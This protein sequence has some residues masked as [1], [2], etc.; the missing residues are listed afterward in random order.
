M[1]GRLWDTSR[2]SQGSGRD[3]LSHAFADAGMCLTPDGS[4]LLSTDLHV[5]C[6]SQ[7]DLS[8]NFLCGVWFEFGQQKGTY[9]TKGIEAIAHTLRVTTSLK[10][11]R[12]LALVL[13]PLMYDRCLH[14]LLRKAHACIRCSCLQLNLGRNQVG[15]KGAEALAPGLATSRSLK[16]LNLSYN[17]IGPKLGT[18]M[19]EVLKANG[20]L[21]SLDLKENNI[22]SKGAKAMGEALAANSSLKDCQ[23]RCNNL[24]SEGWATIFNTLCQSSTNQIVTWDLSNEGIISETAGVTNSLAKYLSA[25]PSLTALDA[26][27]NTWSAAAV[28]QLNAV[29]A[30]RSSRISI[31]L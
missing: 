11:V 28:K 10:V 6:P 30:K 20:L 3:R 8:D 16:S 14:A 27:Y 24:G 9:T 5:P 22:G 17:D 12:S 2:G 7:L 1:H 25:S 31:E 19:A 29:N 23:L 21:T 13:P 26:Q 15:L 18:S 4:L